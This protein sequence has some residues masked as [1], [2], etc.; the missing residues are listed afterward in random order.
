MAKEVGKCCLAAAAAAAKEDADGVEEPLEG[1]R[2]NLPPP[3]PHA[4]S[5]QGQRASKT[6][7]K[8]G[9]EGGGVGGGMVRGYG[10]VGGGG[11]SGVGSGSEKH[12]HGHVDKTRRNWAPQSRPHRMRKAG[13]GGAG[14]FAERLSLNGVAAAVV[15]PPW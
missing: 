2:R 12:E 3:P 5:G 7:G 6:W 10:G 1:P 4:H 9:R 11:G 13:R 14:V 8:T 15:S